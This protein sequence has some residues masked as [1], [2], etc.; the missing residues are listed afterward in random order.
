MIK[1][2]C[3]KKLH[4]LLLSKMFKLAKAGSL[5]VKSKLALGPSKKNDSG[6]PKASVIMPYSSGAEPLSDAS[7][8]GLESLRRTRSV[9]ILN[10][11]G[12]MEAVR[13]LLG[14]NDIAS[15]ARYLGPSNPMDALLVSRSNEI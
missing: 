4:P 6:A 2:V 9:Y 3:V 13:V 15:T 7:Q 14:M 5:V 1:S 10:Q 8:Y 11:T 12:N